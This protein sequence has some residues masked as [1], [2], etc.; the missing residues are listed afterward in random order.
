MFGNAWFRP[1]PVLGVIA[2]KIK[3]TRLSLFQSLNPVIISEVEMIYLLRWSQFW[4][5]TVVNAL[6]EDG[7]VGTI[8]HAS[9]EI[10]DLWGCRH[11]CQWWWR[12]RTHL[13]WGCWWGESWGHSWVLTL[14][15]HWQPP[16][17]KPEENL[18]LSP[19]TAS[20]LLPCNL[21]NQKHLSH[22]SPF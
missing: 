17:S 7:K 10:P 1:P 3:G 21:L 8:P 5:N 13:N 6:L 18:F 14:M 4:N 16:V 15:M 19:E 22:M 12:A 20:L 9:K 2:R 11:C